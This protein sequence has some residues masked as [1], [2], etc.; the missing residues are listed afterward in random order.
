VIEDVPEP[1]DVSMSSRVY[2]KLRDL[3][4]IATER[5]DGEAYV[6]ALREFFRRLK[7]Y[8]QF[9]DP[10]IEL[11]QEHGQI[12]IGIIPPLAMRYGVLE[13]RRKV[14]VAA[15]PVLLPMTLTSL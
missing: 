10:L 13:H 15:L 3:A 12:R 4:F 6:K 2:D 14:F 9:G 1:Y 11:Q 8:P 7:V 5:G